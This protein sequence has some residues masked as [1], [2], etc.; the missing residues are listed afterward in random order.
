MG[1]FKKQKGVTM[2]A[3]VVTI[4]VMLIIASIM[5]AT[6]SGKSGM[7][8]KATDSQIM[9]EL[10]QL[11]DTLNSKRAE[12]EGKRLKAGDYSGELSN[13]DLQDNNI[14]SS[15]KYL[16]QLNIRVGLVNLKEL[17]VTSNL[18]NNQTTY[19]ENEYERLTS[20]T[21]VFAL[22]LSNNTLYYVRDGKIWSLKGDVNE[23]DLISKVES[24]KIQ[25]TA[26]PN[27]D[28]WT[29]KDVKVTIEY[30]NSLTNKTYKLSDEAE[31]TVT[32]NKVERA[33]SSNTQIIAE[34]KNGNKD[35]TEKYTVKNIDKEAPKIILKNTGDKML[36]DGTATIK[37]QVN[38]NDE[39]G[40]Q[41]A[42]QK[43][44]WS[45]SKDVEPTGEDWK[46]VTDDEITKKVTELGDWYLWVIATDNAS[47]KTQQVLKCSITEGIAKIVETNV[48][49]PSVQDAI[50]QCLKDGTKA[51]IQLLRDT[52][53][54]CNVY[55]GQNITLDLNGNTI[56]NNLYNMCTIQNNGT[57]SIIDSSTD[58][59]KIG[60]ITSENNIAIKN[61]E[62]ATII[63]GSD[64]SDVSIIRPEIIGQ[65]NGILNDGTFN[66]YDGIIKANKAIKGDVTATPTDYSA[67]T[68][69]EDNGEVAILGRLADYSARIGHIYYSTLQE[70]VDK[71]KE[72]DIIYLV[73]PN[74]LQETLIIDSTKNVTINLDGKQIT[75][76]ASE[77]A[78]RNSGKLNIVS[79]EGET[80]KTALILNTS[81]STIYNDKDA[82][83]TINDVKIQ[84]TKGG[85][86]SSGK[87]YR[88]STIYNAGKLVTNENTEVLAT[89]SYSYAI[90]NEGTYICNSVNISTGEYGIYNKL[91][92]TQISNIAITK[93]IC[94]E[95]GNLEIMGGTINADLQNYSEKES[96]ISGGNISRLYNR[97]NGNLTIEAGTI[98]YIENYSSKDFDI[99]NATIG[100][101]INY[102]E[103]TVNLNNIKGSNG[104]TNRGTG[105]V[106]II[107]STRSN[108]SFEGSGNIF[109]ENSTIN[110]INNK[111]SATVYIKSGNVLNGITNSG[112]G[113]IQLGEDDDKE[114][115]TVPEING[116]INM[117]SGILNFYDGKI[118]GNPPVFANSINIPK[119]SEII[120]N[121]ENNNE[122][123]TL[124]KQIP[125]IASI[126]KD[127]KVV[128]YKKM[129]DA[130]DACI[131][132]EE[133]K[134]TVLRNQVS[135]E[136]LNISKEKIINIDMA[137][138]SITTLVN[139]Y[140]NNNGNLTIEGGGTF[141]SSIGNIITNNEGANL[142][143]DGSSFN[144]KKSGNSVVQNSGLLQILSGNISAVSKTIDNKGEGT[145]KM[146][147]GTVNASTYAIYNTSS[148]K[149][150]IVGGTVQAT[151]YYEGYSAIYNNTENGVVE[152]K[153]G[154]VTNQ[155]KAIEN[156][157]GTIKVTGGEIRTT[158]GDT[159][160]SECG[161]YN[162]GKV[163]I[164]D[165]KVAALY[166]GSGIQN[167]GGTIEITGGTVSAPEWYN[168]IINRGTLE[169]S[170]G[171]IKSN[172]KGIYNNSILKMTGG[173]VEVQESK[174]YNYAALECGGGTAT[175]E[176]GTIKYNNIGNTS[177]NTAAIRITTNTATLTLGKED[178]NVSITNPEIIGSRYGINNEGNGTFNFYDGIIKGKTAINGNL[179]A[180]EKGYEVITTEENEI[181]TAILGNLPVAKIGEKEYYTF[182]EAFDA[183]PSDGTE[184]TVEVLRNCTTDMANI[185]EENKN[186]VLDI[187][188]YKILSG[189]ENLFTNNGKFKIVDSIGN[190]RI[191]S[192]KGTILK[193]E[194]TGN[195]AINNI[196]MQMT[197]S[198]AI[199]ETIENKGMLEVTGGV[200]ISD[201]LKNKCIN[202]IEQGT[203]KITG[204]TVSAYTYAIYNTSSN[205]VEIEGGTV[206]A[207]YYYEGYSAIYNNT[208]NGVVEIKGGLVTN[209]G[210]AIEN[211]KGTIK[212]TGGEIRTTQGDTRYSECGIYNNGKVI[213]EDGKVAAL[214]RGS[215]IQNEGGTIE[216]TGGTVS[217][218]E[219]YNSIINRGTLEISGGTIKSNEKGIYNNS[220]LKMTG[221]TVE[222]QES[223]S[224]N[225]AA[226][227]CGGGTATIEGGTIKYNNAGNTNYNTAAIKI[228]TNTATLT[229]GKED[230]NVS[231]TN[232]EIIG[233]T[234]GISNE[235]NGQFNF[236]D[237][238]VK[239]ILAAISGNITRVEDKY[240]LVG[241]TE[242]NYQTT[243][244]G[245]LATDTMTACVNGTYYSTLQEAINSCI[246]NK[247]TY[248]ILVNGATVSENI[249]ISSNKIIKI[250][251]KGYTI[252]GNSG[253]NIENKGK[254]TIIDSSDTKSG[255][256]NIQVTGSGTFTKE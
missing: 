229:L 195:F 63:L 214:Y 121:M 181:E 80:I 70:A 141:I 95:N 90:Y 142:K 108:V 124:T 254:L 159:R 237:G 36:K 109:I 162:N 160:Y 30:G 84:T 7:V 200:I 96:V 246:D 167:E 47:N 65:I 94:N 242:D 99:N 134:I 169:I 204:G 183:C 194:E 28:T 165:G 19:T 163:I 123:W 240:T 170:G 232:P 198:S 12:G 179:S 11:Q 209:Q 193:N 143:I 138:F 207:T 188:S 82:Q 178:G 114:P 112:T 48:I 226:L 219:W 22:N 79:R 249:T 205:K 60:K 85:Y 247:E 34:A 149:V 180:K 248:I 18:G 201:G 157:K 225:Y 74:E 53:E 89:N 56:S 76:H 106:N 135:P 185:I 202:N 215:G 192:A 139:S 244:L 29:N 168:S 217:A 55:S 37:I 140:I 171:T 122:V 27:N 17:N 223:K 35:V 175:I 15:D 45:S 208:E 212:V 54:T 220:I 151:Y 256:F 116:K 182:Q 222:V 52:E 9:T 177:Y 6:F 97:E 31:N 137:G 245:F 132:G 187:Q 102:K 255:Q 71:A 78:I 238:I 133:T 64:D 117:N 92:T 38:V 68:T 10:S 125:D 73:I 67:I 32:E 66:F 81:D 243:T 148:S 107:N 154:L 105:I 166:R 172:E 13:K 23:N 86:Y 40:S 251:L 119:D 128:T 2:I 110:N 69:V 176:G 104:L 91:G 206:Q 8:D 145:I 210:K 14:I 196:T 150:E 129:Q 5:V 173:T 50:E 126:T 62:G 191:I 239:G 211:K 51:T 98:S 1:Q 174:S 83:L 235:G 236:Y 118:I 199:D 115:N 228:T 16:T 113:N 233:S 24:D 20:F 26:V 252:S 87:Y 111:N 93:S 59:N 158:Q 100:N 33:I 213:I 253:I 197:G 77:Y 250:D 153:G 130:I 46:D 241:G 156:K 203:V 136:A 101:I 127:G 43:Y 41:L 4:V 44:G 75:S 227:E 131:D 42:S 224:Y 3:L 216:I 21:D 230:G 234:Y 39:G 231:T 57:L 155:G 147:G 103:G 146:T 189:I 61:N 190:G 221:G 161:I 152:I 186:I 120:S 184:T 218:P 144:V 25:I 58:E 88:K 49:Y 72:N 164:E